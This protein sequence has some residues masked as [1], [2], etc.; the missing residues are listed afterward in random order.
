MNLKYIQLGCLN[1]FS[2]IT[3]IDTD[4]ILIPD[5][6]NYPLSNTQSL[7]D[8]MFSDFFDNLILN[9]YLFRSFN[10]ICPIYYDNVEE[11]FLRI[12]LSK[13]ELSISDNTVNQ[14]KSCINLNKN[15]IIL[16]IRLDVIDIV[17]DY[18]ISEQNQQDNNSIYSAHS[19]L[20]IIDPEYETIDF[21]EPHGIILGHAYSNIIRL[22]EM[23]EN[24]VKRTFDIYN[25]TFVNITNNC[26]IRRGQGLQTYQSYTNRTAGHCLVWS[27]YFITVRLMNV[28]YIR[29][30]TEKTISQTINEILISNFSHNADIIIRQFL[31]YVESC[32]TQSQRYNSSSGYKQD[33]LQYTTDTSAIQARLRHLIQIYFVNAVFYHKDFKKIFAEIVSYQNLPNFDTIFVEEMSNAYNLLHYYNQHQ[34]TEPQITTEP[35]TTTEPQI[36]EH[37]ND[38]KNLDKKW[39]EIRGL[40]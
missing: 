29:T 32:T 40:D 22:Q 8:W 4:T 19:N 35:Q 39:F 24:F 7:N 18:N 2:N 33:L 5:L 26:P 12:D 27:L 15:I 6:N 3:Q 28:N 17:L 9:F 16:P 30:N 38:Y 23:I 13:L 11:Y 10:S 37:I 1:P 31:S 21:F 34:T 20:L 25:Y 14:I 36:T